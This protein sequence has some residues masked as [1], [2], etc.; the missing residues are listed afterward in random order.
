MASGVKFGGVGEGGRYWHT[1]AIAIVLP[2]HMMFCSKTFIHA[3]VF[4]CSL[5]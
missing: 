1:I 2:V 5:L 4:L 3:P